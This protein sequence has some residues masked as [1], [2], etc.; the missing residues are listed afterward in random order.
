[1]RRAKQAL[2]LPAV[3]LLAGVAPVV[4]QAAPAS[5]QTITDTCYASTPFSFSVTS[6]T[7]VAQAVTNLSEGAPIPGK[8]PN[9]HVLNVVPG[10]A[11][12][13]PPTYLAQ[14]N[15]GPT[16]VSFTND[17]TGKT[18]NTGPGDPINASG[19]S[20][21]SYDKTPAKPD[22]VPPG[23]TILATGTYVADGETSQM[24]GPVS[25]AALTQAGYHEPALVFVHGLLVMHFAVPS[26]GA[27]YVYSFSLLRGA[28]QQDG[29]ALLSGRH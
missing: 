24:F 23:N 3:A 18:I 27:P 15:S 5:A 17:T 7:T 11:N 2:L 20:R 13:D 10:G 4:A 29:C 9:G 14:E 1:M 12:S 25:E 16:V 19:P 21:F 6:D 28:T 26:G 8:L 22:Y